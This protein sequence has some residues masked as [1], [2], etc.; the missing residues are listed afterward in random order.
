MISTIHGSKGLEWESVHIANFYDGALP[1]LN[2]EGEDDIEE[3]HLA[4]VAITRAEK[5]L[6]M[7]Q[8]QNNPWGHPAKMSR[9]LSS[10]YKE[11]KT[12]YFN[13]IKSSRY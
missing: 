3:L 7:Y 2:K 4:Y 6:K 9:Y 1:F 13:I 10:V 5:Y 12:K 11:S 8:P